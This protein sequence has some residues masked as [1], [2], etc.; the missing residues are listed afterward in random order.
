MDSA[1]L[2][3]APRDPGA[4]RFRHFRDSESRMRYR[5]LTLWTLPA[6]AWTLPT[7]TDG[8]SDTYWTYPVDSAGQANRRTQIAS[9]SSRSAKST[10]TTD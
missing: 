8:R 6:G 1:D 5:Q 3:K 2:K 9:N 4:A 7:G 10:S